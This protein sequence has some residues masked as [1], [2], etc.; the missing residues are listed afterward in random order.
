MNTI[1]CI[2]SVRNSPAISM[3][4][5]VAVSHVIFEPFVIVSS[6]I[7][8]SL[9]NQIPHSLCFA[10]CTLHRNSSRYLSGVFFWVQVSALP[11]NLPCWH[12]NIFSC[13]EFK[14]NFLYHFQKQPLSYFFRLSFSVLI[15][16]SFS[17][18]VF[19]FTGPGKV[20]I[21]FWHSWWAHGCPL[22][23]TLRLLCRCL[24]PR[25]LHWIQS[26]G[27]LQCRHF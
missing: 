2:F 8:V 18:T 12:V 16:P 25:C 20:S 22:R 11:F 26:F 27:I 24:Y 21:T 10:T 17:R 3:S 6:D 19:Q 5:E 23:I 15:F 7:I 14:R 1:A 13:V 9:S 4:A